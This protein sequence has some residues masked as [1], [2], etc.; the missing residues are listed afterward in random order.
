MTALSAVGAPFDP[1]T[2]FASLE[3]LLYAERIVYG[4]AAE[5]SRRVVDALHDLYSAIEYHKQTPYKFVVVHLLT[6]FF[7]I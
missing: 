7:F 4:A 1:E 5:P 2:P 6:S 3:A